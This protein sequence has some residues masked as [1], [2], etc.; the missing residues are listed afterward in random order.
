M[1]SA[2]AVQSATSIK[3]LNLRPFAL[4]VRRWLTRMAFGRL[5]LRLPSG[6]TL[7]AAGPGPGPEAV[8][9]LRDWRALRRM[10]LQGDIGF[11]EG[12][13]AGE[14]TTPDLVALMRLAT[15][16]SPALDG[17]A[18]GGAAHR[19]L[20]RLRH[21]RRGNSRRGSRRNI[22]SHYDLGNE[23]FAHWLDP[24]MLYSSALWRDSTDTLELAQKA[25]LARIVE[26]LNL[27]GGERILEIGFGW[28][29]LAVHLAQ[30]GATE[31]TGLTLSP[32]QLDFARARCA[33][34]AP[35]DAI[36]L[37]LQDYRDVQGTYDRV[38]SIEMI[39]AVGEA[40]WPAY[41]GKIAEVLKPGGTAL[42]QAI[43]ID[44][45]RFDDYRARPDFIQRFI[46]PG[47]FLPTRTIIAEQAARAG[48][49]LA[50][51][52][53]FGLSYAR[54]LAEWRTRFEVRWPQISAL[55]F[56]EKFRRLW[57]Y[58]LCYCEAGFREDA[59]DVG[60]Y[61]LEKQGAEQ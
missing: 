43:T 28:G 38:V 8:L 48:L 27:G 5:A 14:W 13:L 49:R 23:F 29:A 59:T 24:T 56:D 54:T 41:F 42:I 44:E 40:W 19:L 20:N 47:G 36:D 18:E 31:V 34:E 32:S 11:A 39:E 22:V 25:K 30:A 61:L 16:N 45:P 51:V 35:G 37:R 2:T 55:G 12:Y 53:N 57:T 6:E 4:L 1:K 7:H 50:K 9:I 58:Y 26:L 10:V 21:W 60:F 15:L 17:L 3:A 46:F 52:E 33:R